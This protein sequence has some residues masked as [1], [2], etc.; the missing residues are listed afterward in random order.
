LNAPCRAVVKQHAVVSVKLIL[1]LGKLVKHSTLVLICCQHY[2]YLVSSKTIRTYIIIQ[3]LD[4]DYLT[5][6]TQSRE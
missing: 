6:Y 3:T 5:I 2:I 1:S 4:Y